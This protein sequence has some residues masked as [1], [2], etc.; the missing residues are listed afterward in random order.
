[1]KRETCGSCHQ[2]DLQPILDLGS[3]PVANTFPATP[4]VDLTRYPLG[5]VLCPACGLVQI[6]ELV[7]DETLWA[8]DYAFYSSTS[9]MLRAHHERYA[10]WLWAEYPLEMGD[11][12]VEIGCNDGSL[13]QHLASPK[14]PTVGID[15]TYGPTAAARGSEWV[16]RYGAEII[17]RPFGVDAA[18]DLLRGY[19]R[20][21]VVVAN[22]V[23]AHVADLD[24]FLH[25]M[26]DLLHPKGVA[27]LEVQYLPDLLLGNDITM[28]YHEHRSFFSL[29][30]L[31][32]A[33]RRRGLKVTDAWHND[34]QGGTLRVEVRHAGSCPGQVHPGWSSP[35]IASAE[36]WLGDIVG[37]VHLA[38][39]DLPG[40]ADRIRHRLLELLQAEADAGRVVVGYGASAKAV[41]LANW[42]GLTY[43]QIP[44]WV[45]TTPA[46]IGRYLP[47]TTIPIAAQ[48]DTTDTYL[49]TVP[50]YLSR[51]LR[52]EATW[53]ADEHHRII[54]P[55]PVPRIL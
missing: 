33:L 7:D 20:A 45:D 13:L 44:C 4:E 50:N 53:L 3:S 55:I 29:T 23:V 9:P 17:T 25:G 31:D 10:A 24:D 30:T 36:R 21:M 39:A 11:T 48:A 38:F 5:L 27:I 19:G 46:K 8:G 15:P 49:L 1:M 42:C 37:G 41:T 51:I 47:G 35:S 12:L 14:R 6:S 32:Q 28:V 54:L 2:G 22:N 34:M 40:R 52:Q 26:R 43:E 16:S 18:A